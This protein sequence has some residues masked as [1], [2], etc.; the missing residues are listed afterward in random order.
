VE[1]GAWDD[2]QHA[3]IPGLTPPNA[4]RIVVSRR[5]P[6]LLMSHFG[7]NAPRVRA[8]AVGWLSTDS[9]AAVRRVIL[10]Q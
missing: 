8:R 7:V 1:L 9:A 4:V 5:A 6:G 2:F 10:A 3:F